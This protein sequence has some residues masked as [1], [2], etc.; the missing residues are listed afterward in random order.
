MTS[1][2]NHS[3]GKKERGSLYHSGTLKTVIIRYAG[4]HKM[5]RITILVRTE[6]A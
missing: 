4:E 5:S 2:T 1:D 3:K 6:T